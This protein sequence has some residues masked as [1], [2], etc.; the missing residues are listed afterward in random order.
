M[1]TFWAKYAYTDD[2]IMAQSVSEKFVPG[3]DLILSSQ[4]G[5]AQKLIFRTTIMDL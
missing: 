3:F 2:P 5:L 4:T 1:Q